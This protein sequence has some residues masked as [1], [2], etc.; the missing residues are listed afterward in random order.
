MS[1]SAGFVGHGSFLLSCDSFVR[2]TGRNRMPWQGH[3]F[4]LSPGIAVILESR[5][6]ARSCAKYARAA[7]RSGPFEAAGG[8][9]DAGAGTRLWLRR[10]TFA[11]PDLELPLGLLHFRESSS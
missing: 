10:S 4:Q 8:D 9:G 1:L 2:A 6:V 7:S 3:L 5:R 11:G